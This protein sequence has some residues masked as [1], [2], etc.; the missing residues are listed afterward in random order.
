MRPLTVDDRVEFLPVLPS[1]AIAETRDFYQ[2]K[3]GFDQLV[4]EGQSYL[5]VRRNFLDLRLELHFWLTD[6]RTLP[7]NSSVYFRGGGVDA[8]HAE[9][10]GRNLPRL[11]PM[12]VREWGMEEFYVWDPHGNLLRF[13]HTAPAVS[14]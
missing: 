4:Y 1:L 6:D 12:T 9:F 7:E 5:I 10:S 11:S 3:L 2:A 14:T 13:G 8:L